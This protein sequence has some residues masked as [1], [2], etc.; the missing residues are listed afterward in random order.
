MAISRS[1]RDQ[2]RS[3][4]KKRPRASCCVMV[5]APRTTEVSRALVRAARPTARTSTPWWKTFT[6]KMTVLGELVEHHADEEEKDMFPLAQEARRG[7]AQSGRRADGRAG[8]RAHGPGGRA[9]GTR[10]AQLE[11]SR[12]PSGVRRGRR[13]V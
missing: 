13:W 9:R 12:Q 11:S 1:F 7:A 4:L 3:R 2:V 10:P 5:L 8:G 6:A